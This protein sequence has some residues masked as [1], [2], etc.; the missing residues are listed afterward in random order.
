MPFVDRVL[1]GPAWV[2]MLG[3]LLAG[4]VF[5]NVS[6][7][8]LNRG[9]ATT[10]AQSSALERTNS[11]LRERVAK[12]DSGERIQQLAAARGFIMP[13]PGDV[14]FL[15]PHST[16][17][18]LAA[19]RITP[20]SSTSTSTTTTSTSTATTATPTTTATTTATTTPAPTTSATTPAA[21]T[22]TPAATQAPVVQAAPVT[23]A[24]P[25]TTVTP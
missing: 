5:L 8:E 11:A 6:V 16:D 4:I 3:V 1:R 9:I 15:R 24:T 22:T 7:L 14:G 2:A 20:P 25:T 17:Y 10:D 19:R 18:K 21:T 13:Q 23:A 12:L